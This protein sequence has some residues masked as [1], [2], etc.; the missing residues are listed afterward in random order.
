MSECHT[1]TVRGY[2]IMFAGVGREWL[3]ISQIDRG[4]LLIP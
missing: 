3:I 2:A 1:D 4:S